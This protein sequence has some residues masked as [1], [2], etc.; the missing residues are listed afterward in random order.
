MGSIAG[1]SALLLLQLDRQINQRLTQAQFR[2]FAVS[3]PRGGGWLP[4]VSP[5]GNPCN[6]NEP[7][8]HVLDARFEVKPGK[9]RKAILSQWECRKGT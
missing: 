4:T 2:R 9:Q 6:T 1:S 3:L 7:E 8:K 5:N